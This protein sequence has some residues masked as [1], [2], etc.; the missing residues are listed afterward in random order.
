ML[1]AGE[2][3]GGKRE[4]RREGD[5]WVE[6]VRSGGYVEYYR[7]TWLWEESEIGTV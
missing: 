2:R 6:F 3:I 5:G 7:R 4:R 1:R